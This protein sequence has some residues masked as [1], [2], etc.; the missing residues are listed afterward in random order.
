MLKSQG[1][2][3]FETTTG[4]RGLGALLA[5]SRSSSRTSW[6][7]WIV[8]SETIAS[9]STYRGVEGGREFGGCVVISHRIVWLEQFIRKERLVKC[10][11]RLRHTRLVA[12]LM[13]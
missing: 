2:G 1:S 12:Y 7:V 8:R 13:L 4:G 9:I 6:D 3:S 5:T 10:T 11:A